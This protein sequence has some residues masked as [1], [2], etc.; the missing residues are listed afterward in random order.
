MRLRLCVVSLLLTPGLWG[1]VDALCKD[2]EVPEL[3]SETQDALY[4]LDFERAEAACDQLIS[5]SPEDPTGY[6]LLSIVRWSQLLQAARNITLDEYSTPTPLTKGKTYKPIAKES[7]AFHQITDKLLDLCQRLLELDPDN[8][9]A[10]Y[11]EGVAYENLSSEQLGILKKMRPGIGLGKKAVVIHRRVLKE[12]PSFVDADLSVATSEFASATL[13][14]TLK[15]IAF[16]LGYRGNK[17]EALQ[18]LENVAKNGVYRRLDAQ[19]VLALLE[20]WKGDPNRAV[21]IFT[22]LTEQYPENY[23]IQINLAAILEDRLENPKA[24]LS[25]YNDLL[26]NEGARERGLKRGE[27]HYRIGRTYY[28]LREYSKA[29]EAFGLAVESEVSEKETIPLSYYYMAL[30]NEE[31]GDRQQ[32][33]DNY[34][35]VLRYCGPKEVL[36]NELKKARKEVKRSNPSSR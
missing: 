1:T 19:V 26:E 8:I 15:W 6:A 36:K 18:K 32:A 20:A 12:D 22:R 21:Q 13:P 23:P 29:L 7:Q 14:W 2:A 3:V 31:Q 34:R 25:V 28:R 9:L 27:I 35:Q 11:F 10:Q 33:I 17:E 4:R 16:L 24:A 5:Q 30:I